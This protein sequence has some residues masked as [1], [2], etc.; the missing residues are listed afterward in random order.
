MYDYYDDYSSGFDALE[1]LSSL[2]DIL[3]KIG[4]LITLIAI[5]IGVVQCFWGYKYYRFTIALSGF[6]TGSTIGIALGLFFA[7]S[8]EFES[9]KNC[10]DIRYSLNGHMRSN[11]CNDS[12]CF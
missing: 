10:N 9:L 6:I 8:S 1:I 5:V 12:I 7:L 11:W 3:D 4:V 2:P